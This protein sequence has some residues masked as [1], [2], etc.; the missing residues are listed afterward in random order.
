V[1][2]MP[3]RPSI[4]T[5][6]SPARIHPPQFPRRILTHNPNNDS[7][8][9]A[10]STYSEILDIYNA[11]N[12]PAEN[13]V[14][15]YDDWIKRLKSDKARIPDDILS[16]TPATASLIKKH[17]KRAKKAAKVDK[18]KEWQEGRDG[19]FT[20]PSFLFLDVEVLMV[21]PLQPYYQ[22]HIRLVDTR[23]SMKPDK[24]KKK[25]ERGPT[26]MG[27]LFEGKYACMGVVEVEPIEEVK[28]DINDAL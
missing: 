3:R 18:F 15:E 23:L 28:V 16:V 10:H 14:K 12:L 9:T 4:Y 13:P 22:R 5:D 20:F 11:P 1:I 7:Q 6:H 2:N 27:D 17:N 8:I 19:P 25:E 26:K 21:D 24:K